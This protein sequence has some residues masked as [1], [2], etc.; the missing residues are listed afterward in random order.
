[1]QLGTPAAQAFR[2]AGQHP[3]PQL[4]PHAVAALTGSSPGQASRAL[5]E[6]SRAC[7]I[8]PAGPGRYAMHDL[9]RGYARELAAGRDSAARLQAAMTRLLGYYRSAAAAAM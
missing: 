3:G 9:L 6:L 4:E 7:M 2:L 8:Q 5:E 1:R